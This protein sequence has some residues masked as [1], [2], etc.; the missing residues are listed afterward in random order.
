[1]TIRSFTILK[2]KID[3]LTVFINGKERR[4]VRHT[5]EKYIPPSRRGKWW[6]VT[7]EGK[8][9]SREIKVNCNG[10]E[11]RSMSECA[12]QTGISKSKVSKIVAGQRSEFNISKIVG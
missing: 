12:R 9:H 11:Y 2:E 10:V 3:H 5:R 7:G 6:K 8:G 4:L 1:M